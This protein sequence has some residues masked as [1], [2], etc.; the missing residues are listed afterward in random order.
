MLRQ[1]LI[2]NIWLSHLVGCLSLYA[3]PCVKPT[4]N[5]RTSGHCMRTFRAAN[6]V[7][8][9]STTVNVVP[10]TTHSP[11]PPY[12]FFFFFLFFFSPL[13]D[14][15]K[16]WIEKFILP[17]LSLLASLPKSA[18]ADHFVGGQTTVALLSEVTRRLMSRGWLFFTCVLEDYTVSVFRVEESKLRH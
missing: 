15:G 17:S 9:L 7:R 10:V 16:H 5:S 11:T 4:S 12:L 6:T 2:I 3:L 1:K 8:S 14:V 13:P 18:A